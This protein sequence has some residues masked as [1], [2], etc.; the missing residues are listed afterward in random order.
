MN[1]HKFKKI[2]RKY[3]AIVSRNKSNQIFKLLIPF[4]CFYSTHLL[5]ESQIETHA[6]RSASL[7]ED[8]SVNCIVTYLGN[9]LRFKTDKC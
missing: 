2:K 6:C 4:L 9:I 1:A 3:I 5:Q 7:L 8:Y